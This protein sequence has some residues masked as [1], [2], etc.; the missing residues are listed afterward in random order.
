MFQKLVGGYDGSKGG[1][2]ALHHA[3]VMAREYRAKI[4]ALWVREPLPR[5]SDLP[6]E[7][8]G[9]KE[10]ADDYFGDRQKEVEAVATELG[11]SIP[12]EKRR[13]HTAQTIEKCFG[14]GREA[15][16]LVWDSVPL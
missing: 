8:E 14:G 12:W 9:E 1:K 15:F 2:A 16:V 6:G 10:A 13:G 7:F 3:A 5:H 4:T 11:I